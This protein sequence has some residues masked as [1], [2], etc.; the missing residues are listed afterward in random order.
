MIEWHLPLI[1]ST[2]DMM[3]GS[4]GSQQIVYLGAAEGL[5]VGSTCWIWR[6]IESCKSI[7]NKAYVF[8]NIRVLL[9]P[10]A[11]WVQTEP[12]TPKMKIF[13]TTHMV[14]N[15][16]NSNDKIWDREDLLDEWWKF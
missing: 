14:V 6:G 8:L 2:I 3:V 10:W 7:I 15:L 11:W 16:L 12:Q 13:N 4:Y 5:Q 1:F 9:D